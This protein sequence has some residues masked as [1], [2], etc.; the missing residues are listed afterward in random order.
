MTD[1]CSATRLF[2]P[3]GRG[4]G[5]AAFQTGFVVGLLFVLLLIPLMWN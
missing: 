4:D 1:S 2:C 3:L 5:H